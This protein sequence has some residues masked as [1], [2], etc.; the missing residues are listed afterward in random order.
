MELVIVAIVMFAIGALASYLVTHS[1][2]AASPAISATNVLL[3]NDDQLRLLFELT[4][5]GLSV[6]APDGR[7][8]FIN[9][10]FRDALGYTAEELLKLRFQD[11]THPDDLEAS[12]RL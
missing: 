9:K 1:R 6:T 3:N 10:A 8:M 11:I 2:V 12:L 5:V 7:L 4:P